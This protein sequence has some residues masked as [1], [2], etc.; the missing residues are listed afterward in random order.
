MPSITILGLPAC[1]SIQPGQHYVSFWNKDRND[2]F[3]IIQ[4]LRNGTL[5]GYDKAKQKAIVLAAQQFAFKFTTLHAR[6]LYWR[7][8]LQGYTALWPDMQQL[9]DKVVAELRGAGKYRPG[10]QQRAG[11]VGEQREA[12]Q[13]RS[14]RLRGRTALETAMK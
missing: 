1:R 3:D 2:V 4:G 14:R 7:R 10:Q 5:P 6:Q 9:V 8:A 12:Q 11:G 13:R